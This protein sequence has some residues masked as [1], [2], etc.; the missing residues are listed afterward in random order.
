VPQVGAMPGDEDVDQVCAVPVC[1]HGGRR[2]SGSSSESMLWWSFRMLTA[3]LTDKDTPASC[4]KLSCLS[5][6][7]C[8]WLACR[9]V[10]ASIAQHFAHAV[11]SWESNSCW[12]ISHQVPCSPPCAVS[13]WET[14]RI[15]IVVCL[16]VGTMDLRQAEPRQEVATGTPLQPPH[17]QQEQV[18]Q[19]P[20]CLAM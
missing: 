17:C 2:S 8:V 4:H 10:K 14:G 12:L 11:G 9:V 5:K 16:V 18:L 7:C 3:M 15:C 20:S 1:S 19:Q 13:F 6:D